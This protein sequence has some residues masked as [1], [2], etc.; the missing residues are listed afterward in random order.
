M[1]TKTGALDLTL[2]GIELANRVN[3][4]VTMMEYYD[5]YNTKD[6]ERAKESCMEKVREI[7]R[8]LREHNHMKDD[9]NFSTYGR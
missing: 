9:E 4:L 5:G 1:S 8:L 7:E 6:Y 2:R 3:Y